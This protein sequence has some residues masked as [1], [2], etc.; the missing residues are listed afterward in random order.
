MH[1]GIAYSDKKDSH[2]AAKN[3]AE[4]AVSQIGSADIIILLSTDYYDQEVVLSTVLEVTNSKVV[5]CCTAG[6]ITPDGVLNRGVGVCALKGV[7]AATYLGR[8]GGWTGG[9]S[10]GKAL[11]KVK[12]GTI[13]VFPDGFANEIPDFLRGVYNALGP[14]YVYLG[15]GS[16]DNLMSTKT[17][18][19]TEK[20]VIKGGFALAAF[21]WTLSTAVGHGWAPIT[22]PMVITKASGRIVSEIEG[23]NAFKAYSRLV[24]CGKKNFAY[25]GMQHPFGLTGACGSFLIIRDPIAVREDGSIELV[26]EVP[27]NCVITIMGCKHDDLIK[28]AEKVAE[29]AVSGVKRPKFALIFDCVSRK[30]LLGKKFNDEVAAIKDVLDVPFIGPLTFGEVHSSFSV[31]I[32]HNKTVVVAVGGEK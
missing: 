21:G 9:E 29:V 27:Q 28:T 13:L 6:L 19:F 32:F 25:Y 12:K 26:S 24:K 11:R 3:A 1:A 5:G 16:G 10:A 20:G 14:D 22:S 17:Y 30:L 15:G 2:S 18:Q 23:E 31:P 4:E 8:T 7:G